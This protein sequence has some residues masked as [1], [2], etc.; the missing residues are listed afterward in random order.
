[1]FGV[2][3]GAEYRASVPPTRKITNR[4]MTQDPM[5]CSLFLAGVHSLGCIFER[6]HALRVIFSLS[7]HPM[8]PT[9]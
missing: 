7:M 8:M 3:S 4:Q 9:G 6:N 2:E 5:I 1:L